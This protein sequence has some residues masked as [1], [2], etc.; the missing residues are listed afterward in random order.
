MFGYVQPAKG[1]LRVCEYE[2]YKAVY[3]GLCK[4][5]GRRYGPFSRLSLSYD[6]TFL[7]LLQMG[8][9]QQDPQFQP[10]RCL[11]NPLKR[12]PICREQEALDFSCGTAMI[13]LYF[14]ALDNYRDGRLPQ[15]LLALLC[16]PF[17]Y[18]AYR[19]AAG[20]YPQVAAVLYE[21]VSGQAQLEADRCSSV[22]RACEPTALAMAQI[23]RM[24]SPQPGQQRVLE[25]M[26]YLLGRYIYLSDA[27]DDLEEDLQNGSYNPFLLREAVQA[28]SPTQLQG[29]REDAKGSLFLTIG[30]LIKTYELLGLVRF[31]PILDNIVHLG[32]RDTVERIML[33]K[34]NEHR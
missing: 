23:C 8:L 34:E 3:C 1:Q 20:Q 17:C 30:E 27:L 7:A 6:F 28:P 18:S 13:M 26:G 2:L 32:L 9:D 24:L 5:L 4:Q 29:I 21:M 25:R 22:D 14:K 19:K 11:L 12:V 15:K 10:G 16:K 31:K 33:P